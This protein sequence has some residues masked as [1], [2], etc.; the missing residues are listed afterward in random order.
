VGAERELRELAAE[1]LERAPDRGLSVGTARE[2]QVAAAAGAADLAARGTGVRGHRQQAFDR[3]ALG[4]VRVHQ[5]LALESL[6]EHRP[7]PVEVPVLELPSHLERHRLQLLHPHERVL[8]P[9]L[10][11]AD[12]GGDQ[13]EV[14]PDVARVAEQQVRPELRDRLG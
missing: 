13:P 4:D 10:V 8:A 9:L 11:H 12:L 3:R 1:R 7:Q 2:Q 14:G 5:L 6:A